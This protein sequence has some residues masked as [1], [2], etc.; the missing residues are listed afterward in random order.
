MTPKPPLAYKLA[1]G[2]LIATIV[3]SV[4]FVSSSVGEN[5]FPGTAI[6]KDMYSDYKNQFDDIKK[7][8][9][10]LEKA[11][12][13][14]RWG[15]NKR[16]IRR[17][18]RE[19]RIAKA[20]EKMTRPGAGSLSERARVILDFSDLNNFPR[21]QVEK[22]KG[23]V[24]TFGVAPKEIDGK[25][26]MAAR[27]L[28]ENIGASEERRQYGG[29]EIFLKAPVKV[30][31]MRAIEVTV[32]GEGARGFGLGIFSDQENGWLRWD[33]GSIQFTDK[34][35]AT[36]TIPFVDFDLWRFDNKTQK[37]KAHKPWSDPVTIDRVQVYLVQRDLDNGRSAT[38]WV[39]KVALR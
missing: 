17:Q 4:F 11:L 10:S 31:G 36:F 30:G 18:E 12:S 35:W 13:P 27:L 29:G 38:L 25:A 34:G 26:G 32:M 5:D 8:V 16:D 9:G 21:L 39:D 14:E 3:A 24:V 19:R 15:K 6:F 37:Y 1:P 7:L 22:S 2:I 33:L 28:I 23:A 20:K